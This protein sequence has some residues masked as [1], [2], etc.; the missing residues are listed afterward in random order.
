[1]PGIDWK[2]VV[3]RIHWRRTTRRLWPAV[4]ELPLSR[5]EVLKPS[6]VLLYCWSG[7]GKRRL[8]SGWVS[9]RAGNCHWSKPGWPYRCRQNPKKPLG[10]N[11]IHFDLLDQEGQIIDY[12][13]L[14][15]W[16]EV[17]TVADPA[18]VEAV[19]RHIAEIATSFRSGAAMSTNTSR[20][21]EL[22]LKG[23]LMNLEENTP[24]LEESRSS[25]NI[26]LVQSVISRIHSGMP[27]RITV[28]SLAEAMAC[29]R[30]HLSRI[31]HELMG[32]DLRAYIL[33]ARFEVAKELLSDSDLSIAEVASHAG[34]ED[35]FIFA[36]QFKKFSGLPPGK[37]RKNER[38]TVK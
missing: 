8:P 34:Y 20:E 35:T 10:F 9:I 29:S 36:K 37:F 27:A 11:A 25:S 24:M 19:T 14:K 7:E 5:T 33:N 21:A 28:N 30:G 18:L 2:S 31:F 3:T 13:K 6:H 17:Q 16:P 26:K 22:L 4:K 32:L 23:L 1:M 38:Q 12:Q 15:P